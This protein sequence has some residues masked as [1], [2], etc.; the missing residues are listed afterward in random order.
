MDPI[1][2]ISVTEINFSMDSLGL[3]LERP[4]HN[5][6]SKYQYNLKQTSD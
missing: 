1:F 5:F 2:Y 3:T 6:S 4:R